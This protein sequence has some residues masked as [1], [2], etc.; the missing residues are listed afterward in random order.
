M[1]INL[2]WFWIMVILITTLGGTSYAADERQWAISLFTGRLTDGDLGDSAMFNV[3]FEDAFLVAGTLSKK[4]YRYFDSID[5]EWEVQAVK[6]FKDQNH[7]EFN[8]L[9]VVRWTAF[10]WDP[11]LDTSVAA[12]TGLSFASSRPEIESKNHTDTSNILAYLM[13]EVA[14]SLPTVPE[15]SLVTRIHH[16]SGAYGLFN[17]VHGAS[18]AWIFGLRYHF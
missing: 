11:Y 17:N 5:L 10:P 6:H 16:R 1:T 8:G 7:W 12:G 2:K 18:N 15:W 9:N 13:F 4:Y 3:S 14:F